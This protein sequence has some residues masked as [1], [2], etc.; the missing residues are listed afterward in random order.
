[1]EQGRVTM[2]ALNELEDAPGEPHFSASTIYLQERA[3]WHF[4]KQLLQMARAS[5]DAPSERNWY[6]RQAALE[7]SKARIIQRLRLQ[8]LGPLGHDRFSQCGS[9]HG[10]GLRVLSKSP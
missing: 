3:A 4:A 7:R 6:I 5:G 10:I 8:L 2:Q 9:I 1:M